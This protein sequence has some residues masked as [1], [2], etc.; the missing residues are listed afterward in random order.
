MPEEQVSWYMEILFA[1][2][3]NVNSLDGKSSISERTGMNSPFTY[4]CTTTKGQ[5]ISKDFFSGRGF[6]Q[7]KN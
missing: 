4:K 3:Q 7:P 2:I 6:F 5:I 1:G